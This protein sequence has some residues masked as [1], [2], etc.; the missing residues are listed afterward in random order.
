MASS[1]GSQVFAALCLGLL[2]AFAL[3]LLLTSF[4][5]VVGISLLSF[6]SGDRQILQIIQTPSVNPQSL[7]PTTNRLPIKPLPKSALQPG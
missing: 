6:R 7:I 2:I 3:Q 1:V 4:G 5:V